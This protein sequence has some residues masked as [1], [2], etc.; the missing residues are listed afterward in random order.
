MK[1]VALALA[2]L[3][4]MA[5]KLPIYSLYG[6]VVSF[7]EKEVKLDN[8]DVYVTVPRNF[9]GVKKLKLGQRLQ[10]IYRDAER[11]QVKASKKKVT[12]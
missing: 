2:S 10:V 12:N 1:F 8:G 7:D 4:L 11:D 6:N 5:A 9:V 3:F